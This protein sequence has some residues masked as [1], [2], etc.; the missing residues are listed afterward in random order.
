MR[1]EVDRKPNAHDEVDH[2]DAVEV[3]APEGHVADDADLDAEDA[4]GD[5][6]RADWVRDED[7]G[8][9]AHDAGGDRNRLDGDEA[10][11]HELWADEEG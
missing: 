9:Y 6:E 8:D 1:R 7:E 3:D 4:E 5:P 11:Q 10:H 2:G